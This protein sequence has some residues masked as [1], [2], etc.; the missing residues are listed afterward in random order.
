MAPRGE[1]GRGKPAISHG[2]LEASLPVDFRM[3]QPYLANPG[4]LRLNP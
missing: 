1:E 2:K 3:G 4:N